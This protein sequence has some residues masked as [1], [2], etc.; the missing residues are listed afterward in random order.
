MVGRIL[1]EQQSGDSMFS[2]F[3]K[4]TGPKDVV[5]A[6][7]E[8]FEQFCQSLTPKQAAAPQPQPQPQT[9]A[10]GE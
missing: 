10:T 5:E 1:P 6:N 3:L 8:K 4:M 2:M 7:L 9:P